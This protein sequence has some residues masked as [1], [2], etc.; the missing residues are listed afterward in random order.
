MGLSLSSCGLTSAKQRGVVTPQ[1]PN[2]AHI[3]VL[4]TRAGHPLLVSIHFAAY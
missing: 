1:T 2:V 4:P 3:V